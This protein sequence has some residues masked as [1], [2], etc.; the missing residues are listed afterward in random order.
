[1]RGGEH[2]IERQHQQ[3][4]AIQQ[5]VYHYD[6]RRAERQRARNR[7]FGVTRFLGGVRDHVPP[8]EREKA[9]DQPAEKSR[10]RDRARGNW[11]VQCA[12]AEEQHEQQTDR[13]DLRDRQTSLHR[14]AG[15]D[16]GIVDCRQRE[17]A[18]HRGQPD[19]AIGHRYDSRRVAREDHRNS[20]DDPGVHA[21][22]HRPAPEEAGRRRKHLAKE[23]VDA[24]GPRIRRRKLGAD[25]GAKPRERA[26]RDPHEH[27]AA[28]ARHRAAH[29]GGLHEDRAAD[30]RADDHRHRL[31]ETDRARELHVAA[32]SLYS[33][34][35]VVRCQTCQTPQTPRRWAC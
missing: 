12:H 35:N 33:R 7:A 13:R 16:A 29:F 24:A 15:T 19:A 23:D 32:Y 1:V 14:T 28:E 8:A 27:H 9:G 17:N 11:R 30:D 31:H 5:Q 3:I 26:G 18:A 34:R 2:A 25:T 4:R 10:R 6:D 21:P 20:G 22:E